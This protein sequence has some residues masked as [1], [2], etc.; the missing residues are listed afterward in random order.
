MDLEADKLEKAY[1]FRFE[2]PD[3]LKILGY[4]KTIEDSIR[5]KGSKR[6]NQ[7]HNKKIRRKQQL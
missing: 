5:H 7:R 6:A 1:N 2:E 3:G 4:N